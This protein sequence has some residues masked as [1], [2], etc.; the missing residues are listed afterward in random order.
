MKTGPI[1]FVLIFLSI[2][3]TEPLFILNS[4]LN[5]NLNVA[6]RILVVPVHRRRLKPIGLGRAR[7]RRRHST[8][9]G[10]GSL[11]DSLGDTR[12]LQRRQ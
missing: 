2:L 7:R 12:L 3:Y 9:T 5:K 10:C 1:I 11:G 8:T 6:R 4:K